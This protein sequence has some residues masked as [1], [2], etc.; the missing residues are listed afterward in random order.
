MAVCAVGKPDSPAR[1]GHCAGRGGIESEREREEAK[2]SGRE[3]R[4]GGVK[5]GK[6]RGPTEFQI[7]QAAGL[8]DD[9]KEGTTAREDEAVD[10]YDVFFF[11]FR[12]GLEEGCRAQ[13]EL[14]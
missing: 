12:S 5:E 2:K 14:D 1:L 10:M 4:G 8:K 6:R 7:A 13:R 3:K 11:F 9:R